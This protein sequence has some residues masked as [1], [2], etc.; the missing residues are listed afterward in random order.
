VFNLL[1]SLCFENF[2]RNLKTQF[3]SPFLCFST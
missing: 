3:N 1:Q 2:P